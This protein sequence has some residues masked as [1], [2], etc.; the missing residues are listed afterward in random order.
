MID[1]V[2]YDPELASETLNVTRSKKKDML[3]NQ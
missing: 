2:P 1:E 3:I